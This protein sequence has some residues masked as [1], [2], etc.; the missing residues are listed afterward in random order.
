M[1]QEKGDNF[2]NHVLNEERGGGRGAQWR[3]RPYAHMQFC[4]GRVTGRA[5][6]HRCLKMNRRGGQ[7]SRKVSS[8]GCRLWLLHLPHSLFPLPLTSISSRAQLLESPSFLINDSSSLSSLLFQPFGYFLPGFAMQFTVWALHLDLFQIH[9][10]SS[11]G[12]NEL[13]QIFDQLL[14]HRT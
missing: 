8:N 13:K 3:G 10:P 11:P 2:K 4:G 7:R 14:C 1:M 12:E 6:G 5:R 9:L